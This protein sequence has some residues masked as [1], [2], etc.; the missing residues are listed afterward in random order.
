MLHPIRQSLNT[1]SN[2]M[3][4]LFSRLHVTPSVCQDKF[5][6]HPVDFWIQE[7]VCGFAQQSQWISGLRIS[8]GRLSCRRLSRG[9]SLWIRVTAIPVL[10]LNIHHELQ[11]RDIDLTLD[12]G[13]TP[14][15]DSVS[16][17]DPKSAQVNEVN[18]Q[19]DLVSFIICKHFLLR[20]LIRQVPSPP[21]VTRFT[22][23]SHADVQDQNLIEV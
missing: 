9:S 8:N 10:F 22:K 14:C 3:T 13:L 17:G 19:S 20:D 2:N 12:T 18:T 16:G 23:Q 11:V 15:I 7:A 1:C 4:S 5:S 21:W 6:I